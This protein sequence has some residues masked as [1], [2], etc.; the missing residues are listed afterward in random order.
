[1]KVKQQSK[2]KTIEE[3]RRNFASCKAVFQ[4]G[5]C[6]GIAYIGAYDEL[7]K[8]GI[9]FTS[10]AG[11]SVGAIIA[12]FV[13][14]GATPD[15]IT[16]AMTGLTKKLIQHRSWFFC[17]LYFL[18]NQLPKMILND[19]ICGIIIAVRNLICYYVPLLFFNLYKTI[20]DNPNIEFKLTLWNRN[21][22][23]LFGSI[24]LYMV[25][26]L[27][28]I[29][30]RYVYEVK[31]LEKYIDDQLKKILN[32][33]NEKYVKFSDLQIPLTVVSS[34]ARNHTYKVFSTI[35]DGDAS[36]AHAVCCSA[37]V[38]FYFKQQDNQFVDGCLVSNLP[39]FA[40]KDEPNYDK[41]LAFTL[42]TK[43]EN[44]KSLKE[45]L[46]DMFS[47]VTQGGTDLQMNTYDRCFNL[48]IDSTGFSLLDFDMLSNDA[49]RS[50]LIER[51]REAAKRFMGDKHPNAYLS[52]KENKMV[53]ALMQF[54]LESK[55]HQVEEVI[56]AARKNNWSWEL[57]LLIV[58]LHNREIPITLYCEE[59]SD[60]IDENSRRRMLQYSGVT[61]CVVEGRLPMQGFFFKQ[62]KGTNKYR[63][64]LLN[65]DRL[66]RGYFYGSD[67]S[68]M[69]YPLLEHLKS[70]KHNLIE[71]KLSTKELIRMESVS[72]EVII[73]ALKT[74]PAYQNC[75][76]SYQD[77]LL[78]NVIFLTRNVLNYKYQN[79]EGLCDFYKNKHI[80]TFSGAAFVLGEGKRSIIGPPVFEQY[81]SNYVVIEGNTR[82]RYSIL[83]GFESIKAIVVKNVSEPLPTM[84]RFVHKQVVT[85]NEIQKY[86]GMKR[87]YFRRIDRAFRNP[88]TYL[89]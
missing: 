82:V 40:Y 86:G 30:R 2:K 17:I 28:V 70:L 7:L 21:K 79:I 73:K 1:M 77:V 60:D 14:A 16:A 71:S 36:V 85:V 68:F 61:I 50:K 6:K 41:I 78:D 72:E 44:K 4:G 45:Y 62:N 75:E 15:Q 53:S 47:T 34:N 11:T 25:E 13:A 63:A 26:I 24:F 33:Q 88:E 58:D 81:G 55:R 46:S 65:E 22:F 59:I 76:I 67:F 66:Q 19:L 20:S 64:I 39:V 8:Q 32:L 89:L 56:I 48:P 49:Q 29:C 9:S 23:R 31:Y 18:L 5:G 12:S 80:A 43:Q 42:T 57:F 38:P 87:E 51:G 35:E 54:E 27:Y 10:V 52:A 69:M 37:A 74:I 3:N 83:H 84:D